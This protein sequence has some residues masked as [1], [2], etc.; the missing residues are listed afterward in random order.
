MMQ[1]FNILSVEHEQF[2]LPSDGTK[3]EN[4]AVQPIAGRPPLLITFNSVTR[5]NVNA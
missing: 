5:Y 3:R 2:P 1:M 4:S